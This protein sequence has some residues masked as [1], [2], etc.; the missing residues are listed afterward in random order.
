M[1]SPHLL[2]CVIVGKIVAMSD[3]QEVFPKDKLLVWPQQ[4]LVLLILVESLIDLR[5]VL[6][7]NHIGD[8]RPMFRLK[9]QEDSV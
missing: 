6:H 4:I 2:V 5:K 8:A 1:T 7:Y 3:N 9:R